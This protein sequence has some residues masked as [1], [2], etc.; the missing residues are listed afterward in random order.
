MI[1]RMFL[2]WAWIAP[3]LVSVAC[4]GRDAA[5]GR[6]VQTSEVVR[7]DDI[8]NFGVLYRENCSGC[9]G[10]HGEGGA[11]IGIGDPVYLAIADD[12][13]ITRI[14]S[15]GVAG[16]SMPAF[17]E[18]SGGTLTDHQIQAIVRGI[19]ARWSKPS[20]LQGAAPPPYATP[21]PGDPKHGAAVYAAFCSSCH[22][23]DGRGGKRASPIVNGAYLTL[24]SDQNLRTTVIAG[25][26]E[27]GS[28]DWRGDIPG[29]PMSPDDVTDVVAWLSSQRPQPPGQTLTGLQGQEG[30]Q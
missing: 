17:A 27:L 23:V 8:T 1:R 5:P 30:K 15:N 22:G 29:K 21:G 18:R 24:V 13:T 16:S 2:H 6:P 14:T 20:V 11:A 4:G 9:H 3:S 26:P 19:R 25:R 10:V 12:A 28:P 7:P